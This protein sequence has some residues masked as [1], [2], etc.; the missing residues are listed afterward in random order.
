[1]KA[2]KP[3]EG[4]MKTH[5]WGVTKT[6]KVACACGDESHYHNVWVEADE[7]NISMTIYAEV[8]SKYWSMNRWKQIWSILTKG[9][10]ESEVTLY[11][12]KQQALNYA[13]TLKT[14]I[15]DVESLTSTDHK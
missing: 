11:L 2:E 7:L 5:D 10:V 6:Y 8:K 15:K 3:A 4:I 12:T 1:M 13:E 9:Y 14:A